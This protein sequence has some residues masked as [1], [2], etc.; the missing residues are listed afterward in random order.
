MQTSGIFQICIYLHVFKIHLWISISY[1]IFFGS[2]Q[3]INIIPGTHL[4]YTQSNCFWNCIKFSPVFLPFSCSGSTAATYAFALY[5]FDMRRSR[6]TLN[7]HMC[8]FVDGS[9]LWLFSFCLFCC[10]LPASP[11]RRNKHM[12]FSFHLHTTKDHANSLPV[13]FVVKF[14]QVNFTLFLL[15]HSSTATRWLYAKSC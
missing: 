1:F 15:W 14:L 11:Q 2:T 6:R 12:L 7:C 13:D 9:R 8:H 5:T 4:K 3:L 10:V